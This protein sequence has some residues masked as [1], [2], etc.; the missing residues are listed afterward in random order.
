MKEII[1][2]LKIILLLIQA[3]VLMFLRNFIFFKEIKFPKAEKIY[4]SKEYSSFYLELS[5]HV[6]ILNH[7]LFA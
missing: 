6:E 5:F 1:F 7:L 2:T 3:S 4:P